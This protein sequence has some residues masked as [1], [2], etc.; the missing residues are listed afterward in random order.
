MGGVPGSAGQCRCFVTS[1]ACARRQGLSYEPAG[2]A[3]ASNATEVGGKLVVTAVCA[4]RTGFSR[5]E[6]VGRAV[7]TALLSREAD[8]AAVAELDAA[9][10]EGREASAELLCCRRDCAPFWGHVSVTPVRARFRHMPM[11]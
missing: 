6:V 1:W 10:D 11:A 8:P 5:G 9:V 4:S 2:A 3:C 7:R